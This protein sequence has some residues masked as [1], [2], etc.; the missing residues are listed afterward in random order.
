MRRNLIL[1]A[2]FAI[3]IQCCAKI[4]YTADAASLAQSHHL[5]AIAPPS[6][7]IEE[8]KTT[9]PQSLI[10]QQ[11][12]ASIDF[13]IEMYNQMLERKRQG[14]MTVKIQDLNTTIAKL[15]RAGYYDGTLLSPLEVCQTLG[16]D[17]I[18]TSNYKLS[19]PMSKVEA[20]GWGLVSWALIGHFL[21]IFTN[22]ANTVIVSIGIHD[23]KNEKIIWKYDNILSSGILST[24]D[25]LVNALI[26]K[27]AR[28]MP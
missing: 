3:V 13:Q 2:L 8:L 1:L 7:S 14:M 21:D 22:T 5:I 24:P 12:A 15:R 27:A 18:I 17:G 19:K 23:F 9:D 11:K 25:K 10:K 26:R 28:K 6:V 4:F 20:V 16:V